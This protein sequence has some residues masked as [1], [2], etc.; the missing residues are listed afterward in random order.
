MYRDPRIDP[1]PGD[2]VK[3]MIG[4]GRERHVVYQSSLR[5]NYWS[6]TET[7]NHGLGRYCYPSTWRAWCRQT[8][9]VVVK[10]LQ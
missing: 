2:V 4:K 1:R 7:G 5:I 3:P 8:K 6:F 9:A 10:S